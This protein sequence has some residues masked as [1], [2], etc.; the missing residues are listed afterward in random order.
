MLEKSEIWCVEFNSS[1]GQ[2]VDHL[3]GV[4]VHL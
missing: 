3:C 4:D 1:Q 2:T